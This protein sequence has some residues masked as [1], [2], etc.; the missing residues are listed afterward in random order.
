MRKHGD[1]TIY[2]GRDREHGGTWLAIDNKGRFAA[3]TNLRELPVYRGEESRGGL[4]LSYLDDDRAEFERRLCSSH[5]AKFNLVYGDLNDTFCFST[6]MG[7]PVEVTEFPFVITNYSLE[8]SRHCSKIA[9]AKGI[10]AEIL[11][12]AND[13]D[14]VQLMASLLNMMTDRTKAPEEVPTNTSVGSLI[15]QEASGIFLDR[16]HVE[17]SL[18][19]GDFAT[20]STSIIIVDAGGQVVFR[21]ISWIS[22]EDRQESFSLT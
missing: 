16:L 3:L 5:I 15:E 10:F 4:V 12:D 21:E 2:C 18:M 19:Y 22:G 6:G 13:L 14:E 20:L 1:K 9:H 8:T 7:S 17:T 11:L